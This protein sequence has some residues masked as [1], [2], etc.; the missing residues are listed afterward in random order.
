MIRLKDILFE[1]IIE[2]DTVIDTLLHALPHIRK[3]GN[4]PMLVRESGGIRSGAAKITSGPWDKGKI[5]FVINPASSVYDADLGKL[6]KDLVAKFNIKHIIYAFYESNRYGLFGAEYFLIPV[7]DYKTIWSTE[8]QDIYSDASTMKKQGTLNAFPMHSY[9]NEWPSGK[10][11]EVLVDCD[12]YYLIST[13]IPIIKDFMNYVAYK[14]GTSVTQ[15][16]TY[17]QLA[18]LVEQVLQTY[19]TKST[20]K[21]K[22]DWTGIDTPGDPIM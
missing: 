7:G 11:D 21:T 9:K 18:I 10:V 5:G 3:L 15:P 2:T 20:T 6:F 8:I 22:Y 4:K 12:E 13:K 16:T 14:Q 1:D 17:G 19:M